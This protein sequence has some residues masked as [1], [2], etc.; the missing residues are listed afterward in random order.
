MQADAAYKAVASGRANLQELFQGPSSYV[1]PLAISVRLFGPVANAP[2]CGKGNEACLIDRTPLESFV[3][4]VMNGLSSIVLPTAFGLLGTIAG[5]VRSIT[6]KVQESTL[7]PRHYQVARVAI[8]LGMAAGLSVGLFFT[9]TDASATLVKSIGSPITASSAGLSF[10]AG[11]GAESFFGFLD[12]VLKR[13][14][15]PETAAKPSKP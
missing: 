8:F 11:F 15:P 3:A 12:N 4:A 14:F 10:L 1:R 7:A 13:L 2:A 9:P 6:A 5:L